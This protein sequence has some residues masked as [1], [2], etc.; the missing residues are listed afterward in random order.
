MKTIGRLLCTIILS[1]VLLI[2]CSNNKNYNVEFHGQSIYITMKS[3][4]LGIASLNGV[5]FDGFTLE[6]IEKE[7][8]KK[9]RRRNYSGDYNVYVTLQ[10]LDEYGNYQDS[11]ERVKVCTLN[12]R[13][14]KKYA[15]FFF[16]RGKIPFYHAYPWNHNYD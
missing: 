4:T 8:F 3:P 12:G 7:I 13:E 10:F 6:D 5:S 2:A 15:D 11:P 14:V 9:I 16:F 1:N